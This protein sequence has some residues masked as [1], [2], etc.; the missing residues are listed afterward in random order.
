M[1]KNWP[2]TQETQVQFLVGK[3]LWRRECQL[4]PVL[5]GAFDGQKPA[6]L[7]S[8]GWQRRGLKESGPTEWL[9]L[10]GWWWFRRSVGV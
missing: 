4:T 8:M 3:F 9:P 1:V 5:P 6:R 7:Q 10:K 2:A